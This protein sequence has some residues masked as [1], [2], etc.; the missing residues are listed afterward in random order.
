[1]I[2]RARFV[3]ERKT[4]HTVRGH[5]SGTIERGWASDNFFGYLQALTHDDIDRWNLR[6]SLEKAI[7][8]RD[9]EE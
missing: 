1:V 3:N 9:G 7:L 2:H 4:L 8:K 6:T 5:R